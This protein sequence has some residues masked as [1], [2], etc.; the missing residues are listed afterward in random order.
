LIK[1]VLTVL[2][3]LLLQLPAWAGYKAKRANIDFVATGSTTTVDL[4][5]P[6]NVYYG[7]GSNLTGVV[8][9]STNSI[10][11]QCRISTGAIQTQLDNNDTADALLQGY[12][13]GLWVTTGTFKTD[14]DGLK[15]AT[16]YWRISEADIYALDGN[17]VT[18]IATL[19]IS[20]KTQE[21]AG[22]YFKIDPVGVNNQLIGLYGEI[23]GEQED[24][25][26]AFMKVVSYGNGDAVYVAMFGT[27]TAGFEAASFH[28]GTKGIISTMQQDSCPY[29]TLFNGYWGPYTV[30]LYGML[31]L[32]QSPG[33]AFT[34]R[35]ST[36]AA[37]NQ[38]QIRVWTSDISST[39]FSVATNGDAKVKD[40]SLKDGNNAAG[41]MYL[42]D[43]S[44]DGCWR[45]GVS[46]NNLVIERR[47]SSA[48][49]TKTTVTP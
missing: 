3:L 44:T 26:A 19:N 10:D 38:D 42:G 31:Y 36:N 4:S 9:T 2:S 45:I 17:S 5:N 30:P 1:L 25:E 39:T 33:N 23:T 16:Y 37:A 34:V 47:E 48:W 35:P 29:S 12:I 41:F 43:S 49:V 21:S 13:D 6:A 14:I 15:N 40:I 28:D 46:T 22:I 27:S 7:D 24:T 32:D 20:S 8:A 11:V 18:Y